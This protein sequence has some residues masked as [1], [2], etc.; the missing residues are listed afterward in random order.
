MSKESDMKETGRYVL[1][2]ADGNET[3]IKV[4]VTINNVVFDAFIANDL[5]TFDIPGF[6]RNLATDIENETDS[7]TSRSEGTNY[8]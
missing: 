1:N 7:Y 3:M 2:Y 6:L 8:R 5:D 4:A